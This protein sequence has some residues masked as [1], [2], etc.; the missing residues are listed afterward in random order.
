MG[1]TSGLRFETI[2]VM[3]GVDAKYKPNASP[4]HLLWMRFEK[5]IQHRSVWNQLD[6][7]TK[8]TMQARR[9]DPYTDK[10]VVHYLIQQWNHECYSKGE[11]LQAMELRVGTQ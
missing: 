1:P 2:L 3:T 11:R 4:T 9:S 10:C 7:I 6:E 5:Y 8:G